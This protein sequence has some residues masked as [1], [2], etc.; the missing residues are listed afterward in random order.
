[1]KILFN[2]YPFAFQNPG[3]GEIIILKLKSAL[4]KNGVKVDLFNQW[5][6]KIINYDLIHHFST[7]D[8]PVFKNYNDSQKPFVLTPTIWPRD[9]K[10]Y[11]AKYKIK[12]ML[13]KFIN[14]SNFELSDALNLARV[15]LPTTSI[16]M[17][18]IKKHY[19]TTAP[20]QVI[21]NGV[22]TPVE[23]FLEK[24]NSPS[25]SQSLKIDK[26]L[27]FVGNITRI[28]NLHSLITVCE[29][30]KTHLII[31]GTAKNDSIEYYNQ[32]QIL[33]GPYTHFV[34]KLPN[35]S[36]ELHRLYAEA[37]AVVVPS[38]FETCS[39]VGLEAGI[40]GKRLLITK[41]GGTREIFRDFATY[42]DPFNL[43]SIEM[44]IKSEELKS[45]Y[46]ENFA[47]FI[48]DNY[49]WDAIAK[50]TIKVYEDALK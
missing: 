14:P 32:C 7:L 36:V 35:D 38:E 21:A 33:K 28:K 27:L 17:K 2:T 13:K 23:Y 11:I 18:R 45:S 42:F 12:N 47:K 22:D 49:S 37:S 39:L 26:Y 40:R 3:G 43:D 20:M 24:S 25:I 31:V 41:N 46:N 5:S 4:E 44:A 34:G 6:T 8:Y 30:I 50:K 15:I 1:M 10:I 16:E 48:K 29:K 9:S 19:N